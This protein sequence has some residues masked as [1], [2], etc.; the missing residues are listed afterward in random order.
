MNVDSEIRAVRTLS[1]GRLAVVANDGLVLLV[2]SDSMVPAQREVYT[3]GVLNTEAYVDDLAVTVSKFNATVE[4]F[5]F[6]VKGYREVTKLNLALLSGEVD[7]IATADRFALKNYIKQDLLV[8]LEE[9]VP[10]LFEEGVLIENIVDATRED[11]TCY[12]LPRE[13]AIEGRVL[14][15]R[16]AEGELPFETRQE[17]YDFIRGN[18]SHYLKSVERKFLFSHMASTLD[19]WIDWEANTCH[20][21]DGSFEATLV[22]C[23]EGAPSLEIA[24]MS[25]YSEPLPWY[26][27]PAYSGSFSM[28]NLIFDPWFADVESAK[29]YVAGLEN[30]DPKVL[31]ETNEDGW[32]WVAHHLPSAVHEGFAIG[33]NRYF[34]VVDKA[35]SR[36]AA[37]A[38]LRWHFLEDV[39]GEIAPDYPGLDY[40][41]YNI[42]QVDRFSINQAECERFVGRNLAWDGSNKEARLALEQRKYEDTWKI[43]K[44]A[45][46]LQYFD[47]AIF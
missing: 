34:A 19:E 45:D 15:C 36:E 11:G 29:E 44:Q 13:F 26:P 47:N 30:G 42:K 28:S 31:P 43:I 2:A 22:F 41:D 12:Y 23:N 6:V 27:K 39:V 7:V 38:F 3:I 14:E 8:P 25:E 21:D 10:E 24:L 37:G 33:T 1:D 5:Q 32:A 18:D 46:H 20:F 40:N 17:Y 16:L 4:G 9:V 35:E